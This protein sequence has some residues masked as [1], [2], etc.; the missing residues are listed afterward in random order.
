MAL[1]LLSKQVLF[2]TGRF[3][4]QAKPSAY[5]GIYWLHPKNRQPDRIEAK[6]AR[7]MAATVKRGPSRVNLFWDQLPEEKSKNLASRA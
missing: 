6:P 7:L 5:A 2:R 1:W 3:R 4:F